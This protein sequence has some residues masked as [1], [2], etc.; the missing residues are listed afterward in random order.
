MT[1]QIRLYED[2]LEPGAAA[3]LPAGNRVI[4]VAAGSAAV[5]G[6]AIPEDEAWFGPDAVS[7]TAGEGGAVLWRFELR[8]AG[9]PPVGGGVAT[10]LK[11]SAD[12]AT[13]DPGDGRQW[14]MR[15][16]SVAFPPGGC[17]YTH[18]HQGPGIRCLRDGAIRIDAEG[19]SHHYG[20]GEAW[21]EAG[22]DPVFAQADAEK[23][24]RFIRAMIL[25]RALKGQSSI[26]YV[27][28]EDRDKPKQQ[29]YRGYVDEFIAV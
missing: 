21:F 17:A 4:Y 14:L 29:Q 22:P 12:I 2:R 28:D 16:D 10:D 20:P 18:T 9:D 1:W 26:R 3:A 6:A 7:V 11:L 25:P 24:T 13:L 5:D 15:C 8:R 23:P 19:A 27:R